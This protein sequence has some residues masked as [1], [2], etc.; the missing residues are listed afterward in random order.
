MSYITGCKGM[1]YSYVCYE[2]DERMNMCESQV[3]DLGVGE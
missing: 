3:G 2:S 1:I